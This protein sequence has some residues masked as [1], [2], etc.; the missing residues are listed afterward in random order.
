MQS[1]DDVAA[2]WK[3]YPDMHGHFEGTAL[4]SERIGPVEILGP[5][6]YSVEAGSSVHRAEEQ[7]V[8]T[9]LALLEFHRY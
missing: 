9:L 5:R 3:T 4:G 2:V 7:S 8:L 6:N 1:V